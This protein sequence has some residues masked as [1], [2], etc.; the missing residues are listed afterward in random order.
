MVT[1]SKR[2]ASPPPPGDVSRRVEDVPLP[3][4]TEVREVLDEMVNGA[5][6]SYC[7]LMAIIGRCI[8]CD[9]VMTLPNVLTHPCFGH[10]KD[11]GPCPSKRPLLPEH[12]RTLPMAGSRIK[13][14]YN[15]AQATLDADDD[16]GNSVGE[17]NCP[18]HFPS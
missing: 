8:A 9:Q 15:I 1:D 4:A 13:R 14:E 5:G 7:R 11:P 6:V 12:K 18:P 10:T 2:I 16:G 3:A 17:A